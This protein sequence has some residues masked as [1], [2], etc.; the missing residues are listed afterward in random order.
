MITIENLGNIKLKEV[1]DNCWCKV[2]Q[3]GLFSGFV[4][5]KLPL[6]HIFILNTDEVLDEKGHQINETSFDGYGKELLE[7]EVKVLKSKKI[8]FTT[9]IAG[10]NIR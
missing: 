4:I 10:K 6:N 1:E 3:Q 7:C 9:G 5:L 2:V 8:S